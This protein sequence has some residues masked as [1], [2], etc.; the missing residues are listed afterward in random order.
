MRIGM[1]HAVSVVGVQGHVVRIEAALLSGLPAFTIVG[2]PDAAV[3]E[4]RER[5]RAAFA[6]AGIAIAIP[7]SA[8]RRRFF[9]AFCMDCILPV[10]K[11]PYNAETS[12]KN[13]G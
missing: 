6:A 13:G 10:R 11:T 1:S 7:V 5:L 12:P 9:V 2:L 8:F 3:V 4:S